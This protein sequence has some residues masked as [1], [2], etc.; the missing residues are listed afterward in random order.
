[1]SHSQPPIT[2]LTLIGALRQGLRWEEFVALYGRLILLWGR[3]DFG[4]QESDAENLRQE[5]LIRVWRGIG[6]Y[7]P[8]KGRFR[9]WLYTCTRNAVSNLRRDERGLQA[10]GAGA[11]LQEEPAARET[12]LPLAWQQL[13][14]DCDLEDAL[15]VLEEEG[16][17]ADGLQQAVLSVRARVQPNT[18]KAFLLF[19]FF[20]MKAKQIAPLVG[21]KPAAVN[22]AVHRV[23]QLLQ[24]AVR[25]RDPSP[26][27]S[28][29]PSR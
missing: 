11:G 12:P 22:Q 24:R 10:A 16:F 2:R 17:D 26:R 23:R 28:Q 15:N 3:R 19:E 13:P 1:M 7:D 27:P 18:W 14:D 29:E 8:A 6:R 4:L 25:P 21:M 20:E 9:S 5:V